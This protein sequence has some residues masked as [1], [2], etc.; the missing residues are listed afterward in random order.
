MRAVSKDTLDLET[1]LPYRLN[2]LAE[3]VSRE[4]A[5]VY[6]ERFGLTRPEW[7]LLAT[8]GQHG[9]MTA[10][11]IGAHSS[12]HKTK[13]SRAVVSLEQRRWLIRETHQRDRRIE[14]LTLTKA[15]RAAYL[16]LVPI[17]R[18]FENR[19]LAALAPEE[20]R[21]A[22]AGLSALEKLNQSQDG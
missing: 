21:A 13:V 9:T 18:E 3:V 14:N 22:S 4:F 16:E 15:G 8:L 20:R 7:R 10:T 2:R 19:L 11:D 6:K 1:F 5:R 17:A 12:M